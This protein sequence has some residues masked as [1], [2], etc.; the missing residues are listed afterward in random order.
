MDKI[1]IYTAAFSGIFIAV[2]VITFLWGVGKRI[3]RWMVITAVAY[4]GILIAVR[5]HLGGESTEITMDKLLSMS[6][7]SY[8]SL[9]VSTAPRSSVCASPTK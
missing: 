4:V 9:G 5:A 1:A 6:V 8:C 7:S 3:L 2:F